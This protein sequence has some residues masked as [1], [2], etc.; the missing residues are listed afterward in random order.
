[1]FLS[2]RQSFLWMAQFLVIVFVSAVIDPAL[3]GAPLVSQQSLKLNLCDVPERL[4]RCSAY[5]NVTQADGES[6]RIAFT[7]MAPEI[8]AYVAASLRLSRE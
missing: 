7:A 3:L 2:L 5:A 6:Y 1:M 4:R 8:E